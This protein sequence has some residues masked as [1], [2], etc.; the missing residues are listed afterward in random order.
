M[1]LSILAVMV[2]LVLVVQYRNH[3]T[4]NDIGVLV[5]LVLYRN[6]VAEWDIGVMVLPKV[7]P[8]RAH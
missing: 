3:A 1:R 2:I 8:N 6:N 4:E 5:L 7:C